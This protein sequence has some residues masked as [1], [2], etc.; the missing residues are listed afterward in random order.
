MSDH[1]EL[2]FSTL[3]DVEQELEKLSSGPRRTSGNWSYFQILEHLSDS[4]EDSYKR[5]PDKV[6]PEIEPRT[7]EVLFKRLKRTGKLNPGFQN[8]ALPQVR[9]EGDETAAKARLQ[10]A[11]REF[12]SATTLFPDAGLGRLNHEQYE[13]LHAIHSALHLGFVHLE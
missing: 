11:I 2:K 7:T 8:P 4:I 10:K 9:A 12:R 3:A 5:P 1:R 13:F 6:V